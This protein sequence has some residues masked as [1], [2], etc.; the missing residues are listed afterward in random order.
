[1]VRSSF[2]PRESMKSAGH[3][4]VAK[5]LPKQFSLLFVAGSR[6]CGG[7]FCDLACAF[8]KTLYDR[9]HSAIPQGHDHDGPWPMWQ[10]N[11][12]GLE[13]I[14][15]TVE[16][17]DRVWQ[18]RKERTVGEQTRPKGHRHAH[19]TGLWHVEPQRFKSLRHTRVVPCTGGREYPRLIDEFTEV[20]LATARP[21]IVHARR[22]DQLIAKNALRMESDRRR[23][24]SP[25]GPRLDHIFDHA[26]QVIRQQA[27][28]NRRRARLPADIVGRTVE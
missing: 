27:R 1:M 9:A 25:A 18:C 26:A 21:S 17:Q 6:K 16:L 5:R 12:E 24:A 14:V 3:S 2:C 19:Q 22:H 10:I 8:N 7:R 11:R 15:V 13:C 28:S 20:D 4:T 23:V